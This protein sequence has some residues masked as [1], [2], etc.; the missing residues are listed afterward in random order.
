MDNDE[1]L[2]GRPNKPRRDWLGLLVLRG[3][4]QHFYRV[5]GE[6]EQ[7]TYEE[8]ANEEL[9]WCALGWDSI[10]LG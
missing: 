8:G 6:C 9:T 4:T 10:A 7:Y 5:E 3:K 2:P 1:R